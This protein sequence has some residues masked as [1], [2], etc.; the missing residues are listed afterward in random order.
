MKKICGILI[1]LFC[2]I[3]AAFAE[4]EQPKYFEAKLGGMY[5]WDT[6]VFGFRG[7]VLFGY[8]IDQMVSVNTYLD[9]YVANYTKSATGTTSSTINNQKIESQTTGNLFIWMANF[10]ITS[11]VYVMDILKPYGQIGVGY[12]VMI[13]SYDTPGNS[14]TYVFGNVGLELEAGTQIKLGD[15]SY[16]M[17]SLNYNFCGV[18]RGAD[19]NDKL[20]VGSRID[21]GGFGIYGGIGFLM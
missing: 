4:G 13:N 10:R 21:V 11:P 12:E 20:S 19:A 15:R 3:G 2:I 8:D 14:S 7:G 5:P 6:G 9:Y 18:T 17:V 1:V 16:L